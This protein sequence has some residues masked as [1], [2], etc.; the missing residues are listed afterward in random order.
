MDFEPISQVFRPLLGKE[1]RN[2]ARRILVIVLISAIGINS[3]Y[4]LVRLFGGEAFFGASVIVN[5][6]LLLF[7]FGLLFLVRNGYLQQASLALIFSGWAGMT[8]QAWT[9]E[10]V[11]DTAVTVYILIIMVSALVASWRTTLLITIL[12]VLAVWGMAISEMSGVQTPMFDSPYSTAWEL[13]GI[14]LLLIVLVYMIVSM[15]QQAITS[16][17]TSEEKY[18]NFVK[19]SIEGIFFLSFD[20]PISVH[21]P[22]EDQIKK[23]YSLGR[24]AEC[25]DS[26]AKF[27]GYDTSE[28]VQGMCLLDI[29]GG[30]ISEANYRATEQLIQSGYRAANLEIEEMTRTGETRYFLS[31]E[32][33]VV[34]KEHIVGLWGT[35]LDVT[36]LKRVQYA[37]ER[38]ESRTRALLEAIPDMIFEMDSKG[39]I[40]QFVPSSTIN[41]LLPPEE[42]L[43]KDISQVMPPDVAEQ[44]MFAIQRTL[45]SG[46]LQ[47]FEYQ[48]PHHDEEAYYEASV[49]RNDLETVIA[50]VRDVTARKWAAT[51]RDKLIDELEV[52]NAELE[53]FTYTVSHD[54][55]SPLITISGFLG[56]V[57]EDIK[58]G[59][60]DRLES[61]L[62]RINDASKKM[63]KLLGDLL[64]LSRVGRLIN[65]PEVID[66]NTLVS[67]TIELLQ[68]RFMQNNIRVEVQD[69]LPALFGDRQRIFE[70]LQN[71]MDNAAKFMA[72]QLNPVIAIGK[73]GEL[74]SMPILFVRDNGVGIAPEYKD[75][76]FGLFNK[77][78]AQ[79]EGTGIGLALVKR[80]IE[81]HGGRIWVESEPGKGA[82]FFFTLPTP[83]APAR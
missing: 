15:I 35:Q 64:E 59:N 68:G 17:Q 19:T 1:S 25:N 42:F 70:V 27:Y 21:L 56:F 40:L 49:I 82:T 44:A 81:F 80:I 6:F 41:A 67:E 14:F 47:V 31:N 28:Q 72:N 54:L 20:Q 9:A 76:V 23:I 18:R 75:R 12:S 11:R 58:S 34:E 37:L 51:E 74:N 69:E 53:Q 62:R 29:V 60:Q 2:V 65:E 7:Q 32:V 48:L 79:S 45:E 36:D 43:G 22:V 4:I 3:F 16:V 63:Q 73:A 78:D 38:S 61:N 33:C 55:K 50:M 83:P 46:L 8:Y 52:K 71:L 30:E 26:L 57:R 66:F 10:G 24:I 5:F 13:T 77:L 39:T